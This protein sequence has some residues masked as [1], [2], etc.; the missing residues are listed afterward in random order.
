VQIES[1]CAN[2]VDTWNP[3]RLAYYHSRGQADGKETFG[4]YFCAR[5]LVD[6][7]STC[8]CDP[9]NLLMTVAVH[10]WFHA[11]I[12][13]ALGDAWQLYSES[14]F[15]S[16]FNRLEEAAA[17]ALA[18]SWLVSNTHADLVG[19]I[20][21]ALFLEAERLGTPGY[22]EWRHMGNDPQAFLPSLIRSGAHIE[23]PAY[24]LE[25]TPAAFFQ[26][27]FARSVSDSLW[28]GLLQGLKGEAVP[29]YLDLRA[30]SAEA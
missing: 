15:A 17:N 29:C 9:E 2:Q 25:R 30:Y 4:V 22:G 20:D 13:Q 18:R 3:D 23:P 19:P 8:C 24:G 27:P 1:A 12:E 21:T 26:D 7:I 11:F 6:C 5:N 10:E 14:C 28:N 16:G